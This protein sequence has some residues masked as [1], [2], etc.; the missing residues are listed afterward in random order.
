M[1]PPD[2]ATPAHAAPSGGDAAATPRP[3]MLG[4]LRA[5]RDQVAEELF[6]DLKVPRYPADVVVR[7]KPLPQPQIRRALDA[8]EKR[9]GDPDAR[10]KAHAEMLV[11]ACLGVYMLDA[12]GKFGSVDLEH[13]DLEPPKFDERLAELLG[14][15]AKSQVETARALYLTDGDVIGTANKLIEFSGY[16]ADKIEEL[17]RG[18]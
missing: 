11:D 2:D 15:E 4:S 6:V 3:T 16:D 12:S 8:A 5:M 14:V 17:Y 10:V 18:K 1:E 7:F 9:K 13:P